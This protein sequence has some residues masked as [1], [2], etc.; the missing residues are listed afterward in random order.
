MPRRFA[1]A[2]PSWLVAVAGTVYALTV[3][4]D[5]WAEAIS[6]TMGAALVLSFG[7]QLSLQRRQ[8]LVNRLAFTTAGSLIIGAV[9]I[10]IAL[11]LHGLG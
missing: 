2:L 9:G 3:G 6:I 11:S 4:S 10:V 7:V 8:G 1:S 5:Q